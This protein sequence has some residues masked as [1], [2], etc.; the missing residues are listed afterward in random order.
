MGGGVYRS[1]GNGYY[2]AMSGIM[3]ITLASH[4]HLCFGMRFPSVAYTHSYAILG[5][6]EYEQ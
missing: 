5:G 6:G 1:F 2:T 4:E 3:V